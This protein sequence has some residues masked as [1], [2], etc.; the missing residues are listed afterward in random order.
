MTRADKCNNHRDENQKWC[1][2]QVMVKNW[3]KVGIIADLLEYSAIGRKLVGLQ[4]DLLQAVGK[5]N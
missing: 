4:D 1:L 3:K 2:I 5:E